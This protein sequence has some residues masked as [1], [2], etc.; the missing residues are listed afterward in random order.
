M[1]PRPQL[2]MEPEKQPQRMERTPKIIG[3]E[4]LRDVNW[5]FET[6]F[7]YFSSSVSF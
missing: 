7:A 2:A 4:K 3:D 5:K 6:F 1:E